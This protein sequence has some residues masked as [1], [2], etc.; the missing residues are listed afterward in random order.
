MIGGQ[1]IARIILADTATILLELP[2]SDLVILK[3]ANKTYS[4]PVKWF[5]RKTGIR[6]IGIESPNR[7]IIAPEAEEIILEGDALIAMG[8]TEQLKKF[9]HLV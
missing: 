8:D 4:K 7:S 6:I 5:T 3:H 9:I 1:T 2:N